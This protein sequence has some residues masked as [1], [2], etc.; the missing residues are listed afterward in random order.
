MATT[1]I[2][3]THHWNSQLDPRL[4][5]DFEVFIPAPLGDGYPARDTDDLQLAEQRLGEIA[6]HPELVRLGPVLT[7]SEGIASSRIEGLAMS[8]RRVYEARTR[9]DD[10]DDRDAS[11]VVGNMDVMT[12]ILATSAEPITHETLHSWHA[13]VMA[14]SSGTHGAYRVEQNWI[15]SRADTPVG[16]EFVP[17]PPKLV[18]DAMSDLLAFVNA[19][20]LSPLEQAAVA[21]AQFETIH[22]YGDG[23]GRL[24]RALI[25]AVLAKR[26][27][28]TN[29]APPISPIIVTRRRRYID[30]LTAYRHDEP[31]S[32][33]DVFVGLMR[34]GVAY[35]LALGTAL[36]DLEQRWA[37]SVTAR[38][39]SVDHEIVP[40]LLTGPVIA[41]PE[42]SEQFNVSDVAAR[43]A[44]ERLT[45][46]GILEERPL[47]RG[48]RGRPARVFEATDLFRLLD[49]DPRRLIQTGPTS[50]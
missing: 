40:T 39:G 28:V 24:G 4:S 47:R 50:R 17:P 3:E 36:D 31:S 6:R 10:I 16:A 43:A 25:Y 34:D 38:R 46:D 19:P 20:K 21:H 48:R 27:A 23:N 11:Q 22:P 18:H 49:E 29:T 41:A 9:P 45:S 12:S 14:G 37:T 35:S 7:R 42:I 32:W 8:T 30:G 26:G 13:A 44:L 2:F 1:G 33:V 5:G 15:G